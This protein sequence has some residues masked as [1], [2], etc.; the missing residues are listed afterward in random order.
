MPSAPSTGVAWMSRK[1]RRRDPPAR[2]RGPPRRSRCG[3]RRRPAS[4]RNLATGES[5]EVGSSSS[6]RVSPTGRKA[7]VTF[8]PG[9]TS[10]FGLGEAEGPVDVERP[11]DRRH[12]H[13]DVVELVSGHDPA[14]T[15]RLRARPG[16][17][18]RR[19]ARPPSKGLRG[20]PDAG[21]TAS[22]RPSGSGARDS[23]VRRNRLLEEREQA[24]PRPHASGAARPRRL[25]EVSRR[26]PRSPAPPPARRRRR[27]PCVFTM[28]GRQAF[29]CVAES[30]ASSP[31]PRPPGPRPRGPT[32]SR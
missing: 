25:R 3:A 7:T 19:D 21:R 9:T 16:P 29:V 11:V 13:A 31:D 26:A 5:A 28:G 24:R 6:S 15:R 4:R 10:R 18:A 23:I 12:G 27:A 30:R 22:S 2:P 20:A 14:A 8:C 17:A 32:C 1:P